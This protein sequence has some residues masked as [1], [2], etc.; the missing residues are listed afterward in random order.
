[1]VAGKV[2]PR[3]RG[4]AAPRS[5]GAGSTSGPSPLAR[6]SHQDLPA[7]GLGRRSIP[8]GAGEPAQRWCS[9]RAAGVHPRWR[10][11]ARTELQQSGAPGGP[12]PLARGG[13]RANGSAGTVHPRWRGGP[14]CPRRGCRPGGVHPRWRGGAHAP[15]LAWARATGPS[16]LARGSQRVADGID[17]WGGSIPAGA[18]EPSA[19]SRGSG[20]RQVHPRWRGGA[21][22]TETRISRG[23]GPS[24]LARG[25]RRV[26]TVA[27]DL[28]GSIPAGA[29]VHPRWRGGA[30]PGFETVEPSP[31][32]SPLARG[33]QQPV[34]LRAPRSGS[35]PAGAGEPAC[36]IA[37]APMS[38]VH[39]RWR[40]G[41]LYPPGR[42][43]GYHGPSP[44]ARGSREPHQLRGAP[45]RSIPAGAGEP[46]ATPQVLEVTPVHP[47]WRG[48][49]GIAVINGRP[50]PG[51]SP[52]ARGSLVRAQAGDLARGSIPAG[53]GEPRS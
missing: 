26:E 8:A 48:G 36:R 53:A 21:R 25:S 13:R 38:G 52:L 51:P 19:G 33:S 23:G 3:W 35:I 30:T 22:E 37:A 20:S 46:Q 10:G 29:G 40:G 31:G 47:R 32:P 45:R 17:V 43:R 6:G 9:P 27:H 34:S 16:P 44:L 7:R 41:A 49:A 15:P 4:G 12:S 14:P 18:G 50:A 11:G 2:H 1:M 5:A 24:P 42:P 39:P 28:L